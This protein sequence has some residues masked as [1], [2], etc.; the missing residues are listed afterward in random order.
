MA[1]IKRY[2]QKNGRTTIVAYAANKAQ[3]FFEKMNFKKLDKKHP[4]FEALSSLPRYTCNSTLVFHQIETDSLLKMA[5]L[6]LVN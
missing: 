2:T 1:A 5:G 6:L 3:T 4:S